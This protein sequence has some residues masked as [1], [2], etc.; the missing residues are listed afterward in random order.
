VVSYS[1]A[2]DNDPKLFQPPAKK[3]FLVTKKAIVIFAVNQTNK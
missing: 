3:E 1:F 2:E